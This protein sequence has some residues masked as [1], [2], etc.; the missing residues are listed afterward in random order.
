MLPPGQFLC[1][2]LLLRLAPG[3]PTGKVLTVFPHI[4]NAVSRIR[5]PCHAAGSRGRHPFLPDTRQVWAA[6]WH[7]L[8][9][10]TA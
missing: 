1:N 10:V 8:P 7:L 4:R 2:H 9:K 3:P 5:S 6:C